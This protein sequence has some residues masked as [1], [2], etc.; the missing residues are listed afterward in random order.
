MKGFRRQMLFP[1]LCLVVGLV[2]FG[3]SYTML[4]QGPGSGPGES[5]TTGPVG[6][7]G[8]G[9]GGSDPGGG[10]TGGGGD[11]PE[12]PTPNPTPGGPGTDEGESGPVGQVNEL[13]DV[14]VGGDVPELKQL[15]EDGADP[16]GTDEAGRTPLGWA[17]LGVETTPTVYGQVNALLAAGANPN[18]GDN[19]GRTALHYAARFGGGNAV[20][21]ALI[22]AGAD[23]DIT[24]QN[25]LSPLHLAAVFG[26]EGARSAIEAVTSIRPPEYEKLKAF[27][28]I[29]NQLKDVRTLEEKKAVYARALNRLTEQGVFSE[30]ERDAILKGIEEAKCLT[31]D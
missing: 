22:D 8:A 10:N 31:C 29:F 1:A 24:T 27:G 7:T 2:V 26:D 20:T 17:I 19:L 11:P 16:N 28:S 3:V 6:N 14:L 30:A 13:F 9:P 25:G 4:G 5:D 15:L 12:T 18:L 21:Q 23:V